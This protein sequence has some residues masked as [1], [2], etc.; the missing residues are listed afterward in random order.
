MP[1]LQ[2]PLF[3][4]SILKSF[5]RSFC[6]LFF[7]FFLRCAFF[8]KHFVFLIGITHF[9]INANAEKLVDS[10]EIKST[11]ALETEENEWVLVEP[12]YV[13]VQEKSDGVYRLIPYRERRKKWSTL[14][15]VSSSQFV[16]INYDPAFSSNGF[17]FIYGNDNTSMV[18]LSISVKRNFDIFSLGYDFGIGVYSISESED[19]LDDSTLQIIPVRLGGRVSLDGLYNEPYAVPYLTAGMYISQF[20]ETQANST[21]EGNTSFAVYYAVGVLIQLNWLDQKNSRIGYEESGVENTFL[22][23]EG[24]KFGAADISGTDPNF[25]SDMHL[26]IGVNLEF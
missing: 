18:E 2:L 21:V 1:L 19:A 5:Y 6:K 14:V 12:L 24:R 3:K 15:G 23:L 26:N 20:V 9:A 17:D 22:F 7:K 25:E 11:P 8:T 4:N 16:P 13:N 10:K